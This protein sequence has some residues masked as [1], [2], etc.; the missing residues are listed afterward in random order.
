MMNVIYFVRNSSF[1]VYHLSL[2]IAI[3]FKKSAKVWVF[4]D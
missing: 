4:N 1:I 2:A 3:L